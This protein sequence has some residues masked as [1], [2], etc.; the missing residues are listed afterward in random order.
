[1][2]GVADSH[3]DREPRMN[4]IRKPPPRISNDFAAR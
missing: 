1:M 3:D 4:G 2:L